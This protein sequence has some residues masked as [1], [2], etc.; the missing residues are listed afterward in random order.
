MVLG[1]I[2]GGT[3]IAMIQGLLFLLLALTIQIDADWIQL[4]ALTALMVVSSLGLTALGFIIAW[5]MDSTQGFH[6]IMSVLLMPMWL[7]SGAFF[8][9]PV[10][11]ASSGWAQ[12]GIYWLM[13]LNPLTY[14]VA[15]VR[16]LL[17]DEAASLG[18]PSLTA[19]WLV[20]VG[21]AVVAFWVAGQMARQR[22]TGDLL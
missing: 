20:T 1:K 15:G 9:I 19:C 8:P 21:F 18:L 22:T 13:K 3:A 5:R 4:M 10:L 12:I 6:A 16:R 17:F 2:L 14:C 11:N 7:L